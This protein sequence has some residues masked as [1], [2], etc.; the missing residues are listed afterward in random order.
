[1]GYDIKRALV[2][3]HHGQLGRQLFELIQEHD[4]E[5]IGLGRAECDVTRP[6]Q[7]RAQIARVAPDLVINATAYNAV[8]LAETERDEAYAANTLAPTYMARWA[9][10]HGARFV[11][12]STDYVFG[13]GFD[14]PISEASQP[15]PLSHYGATKL[16]GEQGAL[17]EHPEAIVIRCCGL[18]S[19]RRTNFVRTMLRYG[20]ER[21]ALT[22]VD[23]QVVSPTWVEPLAHTTMAI[24]D[25]FE[26]GGV[27]HAVATGEGAT[28]CEFASK[29]FELAGVDVDITATT[30][31]EWGR[32][33]PEAHL[34]GARQHVIAPDG[35][36]ARLYAELG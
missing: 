16:A 12:F 4:V 26:R 30:Q 25:A 20:V 10:A 18:Y 28:W 15:V 22:I 3:G 21:G 24:V 9:R 33:R 6:Q 7:V 5:C 36:R 2:F 32:A 35:P 29:I 31:E 8:D 13:H 19:E 1:M 34:L 17:R 14:R 23:D 27:Y 11:H